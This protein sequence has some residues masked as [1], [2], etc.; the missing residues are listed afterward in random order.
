MPRYSAKTIAWA[1]ATCALT[2]ATTAFFSV[3]FRLIVLFPSVKISV[4]L[5][6]QNQPLH[7]FVKTILRRP[8]SGILQILCRVSP[9]ALEFAN[10]DRGL[11]TKSFSLT[12]PLLA[13]IKPLQ[14]P[15]VFDALVALLK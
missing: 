3:K 12:H 5:L 2:S 11:K 15:T 9:S 6:K 10:K 7:K 1:C 4:L 13:S 8:Y 14:V